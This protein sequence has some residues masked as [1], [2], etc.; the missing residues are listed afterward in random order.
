MRPRSHLA[1]ALLTA[2]A[3]AALI[4]AIAV[5]GLGGGSGAST[6]TPRGVNE[7][8]PFD[9]AALPLSAPVAN[10]TLSD[11]SGR[12]VSLRDY[13]GRVTLV[14]S[15]YSGCG[16]ACVL[17][18]QQ[19]RGALDQLPR[20]PA[21]LIVSAGRG[22]TP[23]AARGFLAGASLTGRAEYLLGPAARL[24]AVWR[25]LGVTPAS[26]GR[27]AFA[28][29]LTVLLLDPRGRKRVIFGV[30]QLTPEALAHDIRALQGG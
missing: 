3:A 20:A 4:A 6:S 1:L 12:R 18:A 10:F 19:V 25:E 29:A 2:I 17:I 26:S 15:A 13:R 23:A 16:G 14:T 30:E 11:Q 21:V 24:P 28:R 27:A 7:S 5:G 22:D 8:S 9:G